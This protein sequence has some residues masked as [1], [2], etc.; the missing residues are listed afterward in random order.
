MVILTIPVTVITFG[1][2]LFIINVIMIVLADYLVDGFKI[3]SFGWAAAFSFVL[4]FM[5]MI[6]EGLGRETNSSENIE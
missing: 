6:L 1:F 2:F 5:T 3:D 4:W